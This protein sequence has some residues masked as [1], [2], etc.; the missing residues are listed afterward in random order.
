MWEKQKEWTWANECE[1]NMLNSHQEPFCCVCSVLRPSAPQKPQPS[2]EQQPKSSAVLLPETLFGS[3]RHTITI[4]ILL[5]CSSC[6][7]CVHAKCCGLAES[8]V[9]DNWM[10][11]AYYL[12]HNPTNFALFSPSSTRLSQYLQHQ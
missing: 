4:S 12:C 8:T 3:D 11:F 9:T 6:C 2:I 10:R 5:R 7:V 1:F